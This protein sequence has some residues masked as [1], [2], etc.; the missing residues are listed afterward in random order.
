MLAAFCVFVS[1]PE[2]SKNVSR[3]GYLYKCK[4]SIKKSCVFLLFFFCIDVRAQ[5]NGF[6]EAV[7]S[8]YLCLLFSS[9]SL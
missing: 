7:L 6:S 1:L 9:I 5:F 3:P 2:S 4:T 8:P